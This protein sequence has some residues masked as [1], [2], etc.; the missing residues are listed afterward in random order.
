MMK[1]IKTLFGNDL[2]PGKLIGEGKDL[3]SLCAFNTR[4]ALANAVP[5]HPVGHILLEASPDMDDFK[6]LVSAERKELGYIFGKIRKE[7]RQFIRPEILLDI[8]QKQSEWGQ[9]I[10]GHQ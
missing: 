3:A 2:F 4:D 7:L 9:I 10:F 6:A 1:T 5:G 8:N